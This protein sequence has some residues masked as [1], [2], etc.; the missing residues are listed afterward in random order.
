M[1]E[2]QQKWAHE[3]TT[4]RNALEAKASEIAAALGQPWHIRDETDPDKYVERWLYLD[5]PDGIALWISASWAG[6]GRL[7]IRG[8]FGYGKD[9][10]HEFM[11]GRYGR[12]GGPKSEIT[13][14]ISRPGKAIAADIGRRLLPQYREALATAEF[15]RSA[16]HR[17]LLF[18]QG[19]VADILCA[20]EDH[21]DP[22]RD[23]DREPGKVHFGPQSPFYG[24]IEVSPHQASDYCVSLNVHWLSLREAKDICRIL[25]KR[26]LGTVR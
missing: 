25:A 8:D 11:P 15:N 24:D 4:E 3:R 18:Q 7:A 1:T 23:R 26:P 19:L 9:S 10:L 20:L 5:G 21:G 2:L 16:A 6:E 22:P 17:T 14:S 13:V 12:E